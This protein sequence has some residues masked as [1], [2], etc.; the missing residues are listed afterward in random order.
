MNTS[1]LVDRISADQGVAKDHVRKLLEGAFQAITAAAMHG[2][3]IA[4]S[5]FGKFRVTEPAARQRRNPATG[6]PM[7]IAAS[8]KLS[9]SPAKN[10][11][12]ALNDA[13]ESETS[14]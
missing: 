12:D 10:I 11:R 6:E 8:K 2:E 13:S 7:T 5:G 1:E 9:F 3:E 4:V 14:D